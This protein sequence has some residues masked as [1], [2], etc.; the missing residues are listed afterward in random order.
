MSSPM[1]RDK[2]IK[3]LNKCFNKSSKMTL[4]NFKCN[5]KYNRNVMQWIQHIWIQHSC[6]YACARVIACINTLCTVHSKINTE[7]LFHFTK[8]LECLIFT[9]LWH[10]LFQNSKIIPA[11]QIITHVL[12]T[13]FIYS[14]L[15]SAMHLHKTFE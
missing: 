14:K 11:P 15:L 7:T 4:L 13:Y 12:M 3:H 2:K 1:R 5:I 6:L 8:I 9:I 10:T